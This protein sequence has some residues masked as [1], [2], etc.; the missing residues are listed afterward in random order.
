M[1]WLDLSFMLKIGINLDKKLF[2]AYKI[3]SVWILE[4]RLRKIRPPKTGQHPMHV[5][6]LAVVVFVAKLQAYDFHSESTRPNIS[7]IAVASILS[8]AEL[9]FAKHIFVLILLE[10]HLLRCQRI[11][12]KH[13]HKSYGFSAILVSECFFILFTSLFK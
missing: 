12:N 13:S 4:G 6:S 5:W 3:V 10:L 1:A 9:S 11:W 7:L 2:I 8:H